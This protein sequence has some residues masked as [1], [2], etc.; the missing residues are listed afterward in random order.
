VNQETRFLLEVVPTLGVL[1]AGVLPGGRR[2]RALSCGL[3]VA[4]AVQWGWV[5]AGTLGLCPR[6]YSSYW[7]GPVRIEPD[8]M[9]LVDRVVART[10]DLA[11]AGRYSLLGV[12]LDWFNG[13]TLTFYSAK[14]GLH[15]GARCTYQ[16]FGLAADDLDAVWSQ[17]DKLDALYLIAFD[18]A[19]APDP[20]DPLNRLSVPIV[21][22][23]RG[24]RSLKPEPFDPSTGVLLFRRTVRTQAAP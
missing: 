4:L 15:G 9:G 19:S 2:A 6:V 1:L 14:R 22:R 11:G 23:A 24:E 12:D 17:L 7:G 5:N 10:C 20:S 8:R 21:L 13:H 3:G 18:P 16:Y